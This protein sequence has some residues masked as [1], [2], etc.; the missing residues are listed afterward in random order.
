MSRDPREDIDR[1]PMELGHERCAIALRKALAASGR[2]STMREL[3]EASGVNYSTLRGYFQGRALPSDETWSRLRAALGSSPL[4]RGGAARRSSGSAAAK[5]APAGSATSASSKAPS[6]A[7]RRER[8]APPPSDEAPGPSSDSL[9]HAR[10][11]RLR[12]QELTNILEFFKRGSTRDRDALRRTIPGRDMGYLTSLLRALY[13][14]DQFEAWIL[15]SD[16]EM[17]DEGP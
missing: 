15:F 7:R 13:D 1:S 10:E 8:A 6:P 12:I 4:P 11:V 16:Y 14:E 9:A 2:Y 17:G 3:A 5:S